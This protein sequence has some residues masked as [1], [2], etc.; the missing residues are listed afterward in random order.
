MSQVHRFKAGK[1][2]RGYLA[3]FY[4]TNEETEVIFY[5][6]SRANAFPKVTQETLFMWCIL[7]KY[8]NNMKYLTWLQMYNLYLIA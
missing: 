7:L 2:L 5:R 4:F 1:G 3:Q 6:W 8:M